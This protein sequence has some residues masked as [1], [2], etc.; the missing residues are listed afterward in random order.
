MVKNS[1][2]AHNHWHVLLSRV[3]KAWH[4]KCY[5]VIWIYAWFW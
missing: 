4:P 1:N 5:F 2:F 3:K